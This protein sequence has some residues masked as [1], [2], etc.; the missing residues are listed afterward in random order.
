MILAGWISAS[1]C[2][3]FAGMTVRRAEQQINLKKRGR[4]CFAPIQHQAPWAIILDCPEE[5][6][7][8][9]TH[10]TIKGL[11]NTNV[12]E[13]DYLF[14]QIFEKGDCRCRKASVGRRWPDV[15]AKTG[16]FT[17]DAADGKPRVGTTDDIVNP[18]C[19]F[20]GNRTIPHFWK[21]DV[22]YTNYLTKHE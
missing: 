3:E 18:L 16:S 12:S 1:N 15:R 5:R 6:I 11:K 21:C 20:F 17:L 14:S 2:L 22:K 4:V 9:G 10:K 19:H 7:C 13:L 8:R